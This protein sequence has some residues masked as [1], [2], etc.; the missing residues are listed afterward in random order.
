M[1]RDAPELVW[2]YSFLLVRVVRGKLFVGLVGFVGK[3]GRIRILTFECFEAV[4]APLMQVTNS[5]LGG[6]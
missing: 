5:W 1:R 6:L 3:K 2:L 4:D